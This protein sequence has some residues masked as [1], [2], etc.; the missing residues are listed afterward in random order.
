MS[1]LLLE[2]RKQ[3]LQHTSGKGTMLRGCQTT[4]ENN[5]EHPNFYG[6][7]LCD[8][9]AKR[10]LVPFQNICVLKSESKTQYHSKGKHTAQ[11]NAWCHSDPP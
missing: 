7:F 3:A 2:Q 11:K 6:S 8:Y 9:A 5:Q 10:S 4:E 1:L